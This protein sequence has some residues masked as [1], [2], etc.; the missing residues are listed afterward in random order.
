MNHAKLGIAETNDN[1]LSILALLMGFYLDRKSHKES[2]VSVFSDEN[3]AIVCSMDGHMSAIRVFHRLHSAM[4]VLAKNDGMCEREK[5]F[6]KM[7]CAL[8]P[9]TAVLIAADI[10]D[11]DSLYTEEEEFLQSV[12][13]DLLHAYGV[14]HNINGAE[15]LSKVVRTAKVQTLKFIDYHSLP[16]TSMALADIDA[17]FVKYHV[18]LE[19]PRSCNG[20]NPF[21]FYS[22]FTGVVDS[23]LSVGLKKV[24][25][26]LGPLREYYKTSELL[27]V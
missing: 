24:A 12:C 21:V 26:C 17:F 3:D 25:A 15:H 1:V 8:A 6:N 9:V 13:Y 27:V 20:V 16:T 7:V 11:T 4:E 10:T 5:N 14:K 2:T 19:F 22:C 23:D 18:S